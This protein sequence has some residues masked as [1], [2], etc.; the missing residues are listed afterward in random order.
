M[1]NPSRRQ[2]ELG[3]PTV[4]DQLIQQALLHLDHIV[5]EAEPT[6]ITPARGPPL[7]EECGVQAGDGVDVEQDR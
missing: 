4:L 5:V 6:R 3:I 2:R 7:W 1:P